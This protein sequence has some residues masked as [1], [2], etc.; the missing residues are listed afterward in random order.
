[1]LGGRGWQPTHATLRAGVVGL[2]LLA[3]AVL[4][5]R[6]DAVVVAVPLA[7][8]AVWSALVR[9]TE[10]P[11]ASAH[12]TVVSLHEGEQTS[13]RAEVTRVAGL[14]SVVVRQPLERWLELDPASGVVEREAELLSARPV[15]VELRFRSTRWGRRTLSTPE[16]AAYSAWNAWR[17]GPVPLRQT[18][19]TTLPLSSPYDVRAPAP[20]PQGLVGMNRAAR[21]GEGSEF[22]KV[23]LFQPGD[24]LRRIHWPVSA[25]TGQLHVTATYADE[26]SLIVLHLDALNDIPG[27]PGAPSSMD[28]AMRAASAL[29]EHHLRRGDRVALRVSG[30]SRV[31]PL[32][33]GG[34]R[35]HLRRILDTLALVE[36]GSLREDD[37]QVVARQP[38]PSGALVILLSP[39]V[40]PASPQL[41]VTLARRGLSVVVVDTLPGDSR[42]PE[43][44]DEGEATRAALAWRL[45]LLERRLEVRRLAALGVPVVPWAGPGSLDRVLRDLGRRRAAPRLVRR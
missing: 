19:L 3:A 18:Q 12:G 14:R 21:P 35:N 43:T 37:G 23:R 24:R 5:G 44:E 41:A 27:P 4:L 34:G 40:D 6:G 16:V 39:L 38:V 33:P 7:A 17:W 42:P 26:D 45:R 20:H 31:L 10:V 32:P 8:V 36:P 25:R 22:A 29:V 13:W 30:S 2:G 15:E 9:P 1:M 28:I 11:A